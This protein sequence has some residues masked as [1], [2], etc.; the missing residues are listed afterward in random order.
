[1]NILAMPAYFWPQ[2]GGIETITLSLAKEWITKGHKVTVLTSKIP[3]QKKIEFIGGIKIIRTGKHSLFGCPIS[4]KAIFRIIKEKPDVVYLHY[5]HP[6]FLDTA[7][8]GSMA[9]KVPYVLHV[10][11]PEITYDNWKNIPISIYNKTLFKFAVKKASAIVSH[12]EAA[13]KSS[14]LLT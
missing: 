13:V 4:T 11:G 12:T 7:V 6:L 9:A 10:H 2:R 14:E 5:P 8:L 3:S 1:M